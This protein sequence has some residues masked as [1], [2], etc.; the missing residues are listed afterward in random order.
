MVRDICQNLRI[1]IIHSMKQAYSEKEVRDSR[2]CSQTCDFPIFS[3]NSLPLRYWRLVD[4]ARET[5]DYCCF[6]TDHAACAK[7]NRI[8]VVVRALASHKC[9]P[10]TGFMVICG[11]SL[12]YIASRPCY[13]RVLLFSLASISNTSKFQF[14]PESDGHR[15]IGFQRNLERKIT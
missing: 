14:D 3:L 2:N 13:L 8:D 9:D 1:S 4:G 7:R 15:F 5:S 6:T 11:F 12:F 10:I